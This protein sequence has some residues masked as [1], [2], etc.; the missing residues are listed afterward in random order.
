MRRKRIL[1]PLICV[2]AGIGLGAGGYCAADSYFQDRF[3]PNTWA[4]D[5]YCTGKTVEE[6]NRELIAQ[7]Q[8]PVV[9]VTGS[10]G[11]SY[12]LNLDEAD[13]RYD[14][15]EVLRSF[16]KNQANTSWIETMQSRHE[17]SFG[18][19]QA[20]FDRQKVEAWWEKLPMVRAEEAKPFLEL[21][22]EE[23]GYTLHSTL[24]GHLDVEKGLECLI[25][26]VEQGETE[27]S[28]TSDCYF[29]YPMNA[30]QKQVY[31]QWKA[32][33][34]MEQC[35]LIYDMGAEQIVFDEGLMSRF[36]A[37]DEEGNPLYDEEGKPY[38]D[39]DA[40][41]A[42]IEELC[43]EYQTY[44]VEHDFPSSRGETVRVTGKTYG[45]ELNVKKEKQFLWEYLSD[46][47]S[48][49]SETVHVPVYVHDTPVHGRDDVGGTYI[50]V[51]LGEQKLYYYIDRE[52]QIQSDIV[53]GNLRTRHNTP[54]GVFAIYYKS[55]NTVLRGP[56]YASRVR[57]WMAVYRGIGL[58]DASWRDAFGGDIYETDGSH[59]C[60]NLPDETADFL[61]DHAE[62]GT[63]VIMYY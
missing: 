9:T 23:D 6:V 39:H 2:M 3:G 1:I 62:I 26:A 59:G 15:T 58:H 35:G 56:G 42:Y 25:A 31:Q 32:L 16:Q 57:R 4:G 60:I 44:G 46:E 63:P 28:L 29:D 51:D 24:E 13:Y 55:Q 18:A 48:R 17:I 19:L 36:I 47:E 52:L 7:V 21:A 34:D 40:V 30:T 12:A 49:L 53:S 8:S 54:E 45:T 38:Y 5:I 37:K 33:N 27:I 22:L 41:D 43:G 14:F 10:Q 50:E 20:D 11:E 61:Y